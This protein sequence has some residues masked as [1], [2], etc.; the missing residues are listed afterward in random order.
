[1]KPIKDI[2]T[3]INEKA[4]SDA[5]AAVSNL[6]ADFRSKLEQLVKPS[7]DSAECRLSFYREG[8]QSNV[9]IRA[10]TF[11]IERVIIP[12]AVAQ[13]QEKASAD[14]INRVA[15]LETELEDIQSQIN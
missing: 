11:D 6:M 4:L 5:T 10:I 7:T 14:F 9:T 2:Q 3:R 8:N 13:A 1:M 15:K 12:L